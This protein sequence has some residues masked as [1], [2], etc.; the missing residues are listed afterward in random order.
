MKSS[1]ERQATRLYATSDERAIPEALKALHTGECVVFPTDT[2]YGVGCDLWQP[3]AIA[4]LYWAKRRPRRMPIPV[5]VCAPKEVDQVAQ[6]IPPSF[7]EVASRFWPGGL[8]LI[9]PRRPCVPSILCAG[10]PTIA[11]RMPAH[12]WALKW[13]KSAG[14][15][16]AVSSANLSGRATATTAQEALSNLRGR[17]AVIIDGGECPGGMA[18]TIVDLTQDPPVVLRMGPLGL[19]DLQKVLPRI[20]LHHV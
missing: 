15:A 19:D 14:G 11:V 9:L 17:V 3:G 20:R 4:H 18:S 2:V 16:L 5:L 12:R 10:G 8:T 13:I 1:Q 7:E 6:D